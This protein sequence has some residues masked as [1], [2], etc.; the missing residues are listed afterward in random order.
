MKEFTL[1][2]EKEKK[3][4]FDMIDREEI[5]QKFFKNMGENY[6]ELLKSNRFFSFY[7]KTFSEVA[8]F[9]ENSKYKISE[10]LHE[11]GT[12]SLFWMEFLNETERE[13]FEYLNFLGSKNNQETYSFVKSALE[14][15]VKH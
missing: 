10:A 5:G 8:E 7:N 13:Y 12:N 2:T 4:Y 6:Y 3:E 15:L 14:N 1:M 11:Q 9:L